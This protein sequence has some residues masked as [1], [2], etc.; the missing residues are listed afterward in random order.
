[1][2]ARA[3]SARI[4]HARAALAL[5]AALGLAGCSTLSTWIPSIP[6]PSFG[7]LWGGKKIPPLPEI[8]PSVTPRVAWQ[9]GVG[10]AAPGFAPMVTP[11]GVFASAADG[12][13]VRVNAAT[14][15]A[16]WRNTAPTTLAAG[17]GAD[18]T[19]LAVG[20][21]KGDVYAY[22]PDG[23]L[24][25]QVKVSSDVVSPPTVAEGT[26]M[27]WSGDG[28]LFA[29][30]AADGKTRWVYQRANPTLIVRNSAGSVVSRGGVFTGTAGGKLLAFDI[31]TGNVA[32]E[33]NV[34]TPR[35]ATELERITDITSLPVVEERQACAAAFQGRV[36]CFD[37]LRGTL[38]WSR[39]VSSLGGMVAD[40]RYLYVTDDKGAVHALDK[41]TGG[42][43]WKQDKLAGRT[44]S[45][46]QLAGS[47]IA[48]V[49]IE[50]WVHLIDRN[51]GSF[52]GRLATDGSPAT[53]QPARSGGN[54]VWQ[55]ANGMLYAVGTP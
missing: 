52:V 10:R 27:V 43:A 14:G 21:P 40:E 46:P 32:W 44:P 48:V 1:M 33:G 45:G 36:A 34:A 39:D 7:W 25:W 22:D 23:K 30:S 9:V 50:G 24:M 49:D 11:I 6:A 42:S 19:L 28:R 5:A 38:V 18:T 16:A 54:A 26:V 31:M 29:L 55:S 12:T 4:G 51:D 13:F 41:S 17:I 20:S 53:S 35:G 47:Y 8:K 37:L 15:Q 3:G 2:N